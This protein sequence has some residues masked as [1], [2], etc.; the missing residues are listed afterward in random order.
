MDVEFWSFPFELIE[1]WKCF[2]QSWMY[3]ELSIIIISS[4]TRR[5][6][7]ILTWWLWIVIWKGLQIKTDKGLEGG[8]S[9]IKGEC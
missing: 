7:E 6:S 8:I 3:H 4:L 9:V 1:R 2:K 5:K